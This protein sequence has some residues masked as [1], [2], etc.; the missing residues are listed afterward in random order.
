VRDDRGRVALQN[1]CLA[2]AGLRCGPAPRAAQIGFNVKASGDWRESER[3]GRNDDAPG[4]R[5]MA[6]ALAQSRDYSA[7]VREMKSAAD[8]Q[9]PEAE[10]VTAKALR[11]CEENLKRFFI[12][13]N[14][15]TRALNDAQIRWAN[16]PAEYQQ[17]IVDTYDRCHEF[18][19]DPELKAVPA[20]WRDWLDRAATAGHPAAQAQQADDVR[21]AIMTKFAIAVAAGSDSATTLSAADA[22]QMARARN[23]ALS[24]IQSG[25]PEAIFGMTNWIECAHRTQAEC[26]NLV[27]AWELLGCEQGYDCGPESQWLQSLCTWD[28]QCPTDE[29]PQDYFERHTGSDFQAI[30]NLAAAIEAAIRAKDSAALQSY[31]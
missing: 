25:D 15:S 27:S 16:R 5:R 2:S 17:E 7:L 3:V 23:T 1:A 11:Y 8:S 22:Q 30:Q 19:N 18:L 4:T 20:S 9:D 10:F 28:P 21:V 14:G 26:G 12:L 13:P 29:T 31:L 24:A 6:G